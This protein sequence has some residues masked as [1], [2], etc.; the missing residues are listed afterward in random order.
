M[1]FLLGWVILKVSHIVPS[2]P[3]RW[4][5]VKPLPNY[6]CNNFHPESQKN[7]RTWGGVLSLLQTSWLVAVYFMINPSALPH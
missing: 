2:C 6:S 5:S 7:L 1:N 4:L 3:A